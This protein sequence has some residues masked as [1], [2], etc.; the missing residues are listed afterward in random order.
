MLQV[1]SSKAETH[2]RHIGEYDLRATLHVISRIFRRHLA[3]II[4]ASVVTLIGGLI[5]LLTTPSMYSA[6]ASMIIDTRKVQL[7][8]QQSV[9]GDIPV[10]DAG[11]VQTELQLLRSDTV[12]LA[13][14]KELDLIHDPEFV[15]QTSGL[16]GAMFGGFKRMFANQDAPTDAQL[17]GRALATFSSR[18]SAARDGVTYVINITFSSLDPAKAARIANAIANAYVNDQLD[19][20]FQATR[21]ASLWLQGRLGE[22]KVQA[23]AADRA[24]VEFKQKNHIYTIDSQGN[25]MS[26]KQLT[27]TNTQLIMAH[28][29]TAEA[30]ARLDRISEITKQGLQDGSVADA[31]KNEVIIKLRSQYLDLQ[32]REAL[33]AQKYGATHLATVNLRNQMQEVQRSITDE[34]GKIAQGYRSDYDIATARERALR[35][36]FAGTVSEANLGS[37]AQTQLKELESTSQSYRIIY[38][39]FLQRY[40]EAIQQESF[41]IT[42]ARLISPAAAPSSRSSPK[43]PMVLGGAL[44]FGLIAGFGFACLRDFTDRVFRSS[45]QIEDRLGLNCL[46]ILPLLKVGRRVRP[47]A[48]PDPATRSIG[49]LQGLWRHVL[50]EPFSQYAEGLRAVKVASDLSGSTG[51]NKVIGFTSTLPSEGKSVMSMNFAEMIAHSGA[52]V[53]LIDGDLRNPSMTRALAAG[54]TDGLVD[55]IRGVKTLAEVIWKDPVTG[56]FFI[57]GSGGGHVL[58]TSEILGSEKAKRLFS[59]LREQFDYVVVDLAPLAPVVDTRTTASYIDNF[60]FVVEWGQTKIEVIEQVLNEAQEVYN[61]ILGVALNKADPRVIG[62]YELHRSQKYHKKYYGAY[63]QAA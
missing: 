38:D 14:I 1:A 29:A 34:I 44:F 55:V 62:R 58:H 36:S 18:E 11:T 30:K 45:T 60:V 33:W 59:Q 21:R 48:L 8:Q 7:F 46:T 42:E 53:L 12:S 16:F 40:T 31:L 25:L 43:A 23:S 49:T 56:L 20:K 54:T 5:Y 37:S 39:K 15:P 35:E 47:V 9:L 26:D 27:E 6:T 63:N 61:Q 50:D 41:P 22:L 2:N 4:A 57:P 3:I 51:A 17:L 52:R 24:V 19:S 13:V 10:V 32:S 28:A